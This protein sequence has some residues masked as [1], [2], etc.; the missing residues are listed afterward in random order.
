M[1][2]KLT[3]ITTTWYAL[4][5]F[6][7]GLKNAAFNT[8][9]LFFYTQVAG[10]SGSLAGIAV[11]LALIFDA[12]TDP[13]AGVVS[14]RFKSRWGRRHP[15]L[16]T[17]ALPVAISFYLVFTPP[18]DLSQTSLFIW[19]LSTI[20]FCRLSMTFFHVPHLALGAELSEGY[21]ERTYIVMLRQIFNRSGEAVTG[22]LFLL[23]FMRPTLEYQNGQLNPDAYSPFAMTI[24]ILILVTILCSAWFTRSRIPFL[25][26]PDTES[27][28]RGI[29]FSII[30]DIWQTLQYRSFRALFIGNVVANVGW[31]VV[32]TLGFYLGTYFWK[33]TTDQMFIWGIFMVTG[34]MTGMAFWTQIA[35]YIDKKP[36]YLLG[37]LVFI[38]FTVIPFFLRSYGWWPAHGSTTYMI[39]FILTSGLA[40]HFG[41]SAMIV[42]SDSMM[43]DITDEDALKQGRRREG[44][45]FG[46]IS[47][48]GKA[49]FGVGSLITGWVVDFV[50]LQPGATPE[51]VGPEMV[52][53]LGLTAGIS[54][55]ILVGLSMVIISTYNITRE[56]HALIR[57]ELSKRE[58]ALL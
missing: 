2:H 7:E 56:K 41:V 5:Q 21:E 11:M 31:G 55:L 14:D 35:R 32:G 25:A 46:A 45:F 39:A 24:S 8:Y 49:F 1:N 10:L 53:N 30:R 47:F 58:Q 38:L 9:M 43:A 54:V 40:A 6:S 27:L 29:L 33:V 51:D 16:F 4:G 42:T 18:Q 20:V 13:L 23:V 50:G 15:F 36:T 17:S 37:L 52:K 28:K 48:A 34:L 44:I 57:A 26:T 3:K 22:I 12:V 19:F